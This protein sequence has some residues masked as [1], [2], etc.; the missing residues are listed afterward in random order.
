MPQKRS[1]FFHDKARRAAEA[2]AAI[3]GNGDGKGEAVNRTNQLGF[4]KNP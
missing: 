4:V 1:R 2:D 3:S